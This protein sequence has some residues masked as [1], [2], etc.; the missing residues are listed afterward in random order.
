MDCI[1]TIPVYRN[2]AKYLKPNCPYIT[3]GIDL[4]GLSS[5]QTLKAFLTVA[6]SAML[7]AFL[8]GVPR[9]FGMFSMKYDAK[10]LKEMADMIEQGT[11]HVPVDSV[12]GWEKDGVM[13]AYDLL[14]SARVSTPFTAASA[15]P[16]NLHNSGQGKDHH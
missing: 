2:C 7:P 1:G 6:I 10:A 5:L 3:I 4:H 13:K 11:L 12:Y 14:M 15:C 16:K 9:K 8:G